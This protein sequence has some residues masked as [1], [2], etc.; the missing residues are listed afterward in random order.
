VQPEATPDYRFSDLLALARLN[1]RLRMVHEMAERGYQEYRVADAAAVRLLLRGPAPV[2]RLGSVLGVSR[3]AARKVARGFEQR[4]L[5]TTEADP[6]DGRK[7][8]VRLTD[9]GAAY[10]RVVTDVIACLNRELAGR[11]DPAALV[12]T[13]HVL[14][15]TIDDRRLARAA[16]RIPPPRL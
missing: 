2:G 10:S 6:D 8:N 4:G 12:A 3:Q 13:D 7:V 5:A 11:I 9:E 16:A 14:R 1:W 15:A